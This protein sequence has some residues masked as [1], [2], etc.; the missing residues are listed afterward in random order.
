VTAPTLGTAAQPRI[1]LTDTSL[2][3]TGDPF[4]A[5]KQLRETSPVYWNPSA[6]GAGF[7]ALTSYADIMAV[8]VDPQTFSSERGTVMGGSFR[9][10][11]DTASGKMIICSDPPAHRLLR[12]QVHRGFAAW[13]VDRIRERV[14]TYAQRALDAMVAAGGGDFAVDVA[15]ELPAAVLAAMFGLDRDEAHG[16]LQLTRE[17]IGYRDSEYLAGHDAA[18]T[19]VAAQVQIFDILMTLIARRRR[20]PTDDLPSLLLAAE[21]NGRPMTDEEILYNC[22]NVVVGGNETTPYTACGGVEALAAHREQADLFY[23]SPAV[24]SSGVEEILRWTST[25]AYVGRT[26]TRDT[27]IRGIAIAAGDRLTLWN[28]AANRDPEQF[29][30]PDRFQVTRTPNHHLAFGA[31][32]HRCIG[33]AVAREEITVFFGYLAERGIRLRPDGPAERLRSNFMLG[34]K[35]LPVSVTAVGDFDD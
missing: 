24:R 14:R 20:S 33:Q 29:A 6:D 11:T 25:N 32:V 10:A 21:V 28:A 23:R 22:L 30:E 17:M 4:A 27:E 16:L 1:D 34:T 26:A 13:M 12:Q 19:L 15:P 18:T 2:F 5:W 9:S 35:H 8:Y 7:W 31:G 3:A